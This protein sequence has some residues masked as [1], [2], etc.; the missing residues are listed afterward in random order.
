MP[1]PP[2]LLALLLCTVLRV[3]DGDTIHVLCPH[4]PETVRYL[5]M[6]APETRHPSRPVEPYGPDATRFNERLVSGQPVRLETDV[7]LRDAYGRLLAYV[8]VGDTLINAALVQAGLARVWMLPPNVRYAGR[9]RQAEREAQQ[10][11]R[12]LWRE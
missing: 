5:G 8:W 10:A 11:K 2:M 3:L 9:L 6:N 7:S 1:H 12:G 4:G